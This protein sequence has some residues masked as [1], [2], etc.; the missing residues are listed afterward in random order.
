MGGK[1]Q[2]G[3]SRGLGGSGQTDLTGFLLKAG[4]PAITWGA[5]GGGEPDQMLEGAQ[6]LLR[7]D[8]ARKS[9]AEPRKFRSLAQVWS[10]KE[11]LSKF[12]S[13]CQL[14]TILGARVVSRYFLTRVHWIK[15]P[16]TTIFQSVPGGYENSGKR[17]L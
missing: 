1:L 17:V 6:I 5:V 12:N 7:R 13:F 3:N 16:R 9:T 10:S 11:S 14:D 4:G 15:E 2:R 8:F